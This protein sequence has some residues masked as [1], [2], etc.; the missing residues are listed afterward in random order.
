MKSLVVLLFFGLFALSGYGNQFLVSQAYAQH[1]DHDHEAHKSDDGDGV[2]FGEIIDAKKAISFEKMLS[3]MKSDGGFE[4]KVIAKVGTVC[5]VS[6]C[7]MET[8]G[9]DEEKTMFVQF[10]D[11]GFF[12]PKD[13]TGGKVVM[14]GQAYVDVTSVEDLK[15]FAE[16]KGA[17]QE[18]IDAITEPV[19]ELKF[20]AD[21]V[22]IL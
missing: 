7:W 4:G 5:Q 8:Y 6:G 15:H 20:L 19:E 12:M 1:D 22:K 10:K 16:D 9:K 2:H 11:Y 3:K 14:R 18:E 13:L 17:S 21:G